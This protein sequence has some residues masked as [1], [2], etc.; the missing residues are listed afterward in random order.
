MEN[1]NPNLTS[2]L[3]PYILYLIILLIIIGLGAFFLFRKKGNP[4]PISETGTAS[5][6]LAEKAT[7]ANVTRI[8]GDPEGQEIGSVGDMVLDTKSNV[9]VR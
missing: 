8:A 2:K 3:R 4:Q 6:S 1:Q 5:S 9:S 7:V